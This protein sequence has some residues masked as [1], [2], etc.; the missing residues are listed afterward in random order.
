MFVQVIQ[1]KVKDRERMQ[2]QVDTWLEEVA[3][4]AIGWLGLTGGYTED[5]QAIA[6]AR[7]ESEAAAEK[8]SSSPEQSAWWEET[9]DTY[10]GEITFLNSLWVD[11]AL[12]G[13]P[14]QAG[15]VQVMQGRAHDLDRARELIS[16]HAGALERARPDILGRVLCGHEGGRWTMVIY[17]TSEAEA[18]EAE[19]KDMPPEIAE[20]MADMQRMND[21]EPTFL[22]LKDPQLHSPG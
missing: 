3:P 10:D 16:G 8:N 11:V 20:A 5:G 4:D 7:F 14:S 15:F 17:F 2:A 18:R 13:D 1:G 22:D 19:Q 12:P 21:G 9:K 6:I